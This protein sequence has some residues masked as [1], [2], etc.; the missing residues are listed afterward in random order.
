MRAVC[1]NPAEVD[2]FWPLVSHLIR[3]AVDRRTADFATIERDVF[4][5]DVLLW[6]AVQDHEIY[7]A[8]VTRLHSANGRKFCTI[9]A[10]GGHDIG[11]WLSLLP[12]LE[13]FAK[14]EGCNAVVVVGREGWRR[15]LEGYAVSAIF[16]EKELN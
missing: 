11:R 7:G 16:L 1:V 2:K 8:L 12:E 6:L 14:A 3:S 15:K 13:A 10:C 9:V 4:S 5:G